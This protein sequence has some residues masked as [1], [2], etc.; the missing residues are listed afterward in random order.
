MLPPSLVTPSPNQQRA[1]LLPASDRDAASVEEEDDTVG[2][3]L[4]SRGLLRRHAPG[5]DD[6][7]PRQLAD[8]HD[9]DLARD[10]P[11]RDYRMLKTVF[12]TNLVWK[13]ATSTFL[14]AIAVTNTCLQILYFV[15][16]RR[17]WSRISLLQHLLQQFQAGLGIVFTGREESVSIHLSKTMT[18][19]LSR[20]CPYFESKN[21]SQDRRLVTSSTTQ[22][23][24]T[25]SDCPTALS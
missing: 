18:A 10:S 19:I 8:G 21:L 25:L 15:R 24:K 17:G 3:R 16:V 23:K 13:H 5:S 2:G 4:G 14:S 7:G 11:L 22:H 12:Y 20:R 1:A 6:A 9:V